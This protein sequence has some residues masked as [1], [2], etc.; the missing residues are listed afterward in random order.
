MGAR[1]ALAPERIDFVTCMTRS[2]MRT[3]VVM[4][5]A[6]ASGLPTISTYARRGGGWVH[7]GRRC[8]GRGPDAV[9][10]GTAGLVQPEPGPAGRGDLRPARP[11]RYRQV[12]IPQDPGRPAAPRPRVGLGRRA[13][14]G[15]AAG[16]GA[17]R[18]TPAVR[19]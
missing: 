16:Q 7:V 5:S 18:G 6:G 17:L 4:A 13:R 2:P 9:L 3:L 10:R 8:T 1:Q 19:G 15:P 11:L 14:R 12:G